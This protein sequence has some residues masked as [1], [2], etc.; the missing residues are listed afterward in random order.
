MFSKLLI[1]NRGEIACRVIKTA[2]ALGIHTIAVYSDADRNARHVGM[3][4]EAV[5]IGGSAPA[6]SYLDIEKV[7]T[8]ARDTGAQAVHPGYGFLSENAAFSQRCAEFDVR[9]IGP[10]VKAIEIMGSKSAAKQAMEAAG[11]PILPGYHGNQASSDQL[12]Q[13]AQSMGF[14]VLLKAVAGGGGKGMRRVD[15][16]GEFANAL[17]TA[18]REA[19]SSFGNDEMLVEKFLQRPRH[20]EVQVFCDTHGNGV[21]L[22]E[23][24][25]SIQRRHQKIIEEAPA[26]N[27][28]EELRTQMGEAA[29]RAAMAVDYVGAG[30]VEFLLSDVGEFFFMEMNTR[31]QVEHPVTEMITGVD[32]VAWQLAVAGGEPLPVRQEDLAIHGHSFEARIYAEDPNNDFLPTAGVIERLRQPA[33]STHVRVD[34]GVLQG[35][36]VGVYYDPMIAKLIVWHQ[37]RDSALQ[38]LRQA[39]ERYQITGLTTNVQFLQTIA[40]HAAFTNAQLSTDFI[41]NNRASLFSEAPL[42]LEMVLPAACVFLVLQQEASRTRHSDETSPWHALDNWRA[43]APPTRRFDLEVG[44]ERYQVAVQQQAEGEFFVQFQ[45]NSIR[46]LAELHR[47]QLTTTIGGRTQVATVLPD[48]EFYRYFSPLGN[49]QFAQQSPDCGQDLAELSDGFA[50]DFKAPMNGTVVEIHVAAGDRVNAGD[51]VVIMEAMKMEHSVCAPADGVVTEVFCAKGD[52]ISGGS[53]LLGFEQDMAE[54]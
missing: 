49:L 23:R 36:E 32:L 44:G 19:Q 41:E 52:L 5:H 46:V 40:A 33:Q 47:D 6:E 15:G 31:L 18:K 12:Q 26:P 27:L 1:A 10:P 45:D 24:D 35:D 29:L 14:P 21:Y 22:F 51:I 11:V 39:L 30:T 28:T 37:D 9:F 38:M 53:E 7:L 16:V 3:A 50:A 42:P 34:T 43:S 13:A 2:R 20:V 17:A 54:V 4:D 48:G 8:A 25:C